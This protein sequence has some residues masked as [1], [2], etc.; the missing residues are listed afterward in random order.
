MQVSWCVMTRNKKGR[1]SRWKCL[2]PPPE[3]TTETP[4]KRKRGK[5]KQKITP[6]VEHV[7]HDGKPVCTWVPTKNLPT[8]ILSALQDGVASAHRLRFVTIN[9]RRLAVPAEAHPATWNKSVKNVN[10][11]SSYFVSASPRRQREHVRLADS[12]FSSSDED[13]SHN[14]PKKKSCRS[15]VG[16]RICQEDGFAHDFAWFVQE[17][18]D[19]KGQELWENAEID[20]FDGE[21]LPKNKSSSPSHV[22]QSKIPDAEETRIDRMMQQLNAAKSR[23]PKCNT[24]EDIVHQYD[25]LMKTSGWNTVTHKKLF[26]ARRFHRFLRTTFPETDNIVVSEDRSTWKCRICAGIGQDLKDGSRYI[27]Q[28]V[29]KHFLSENH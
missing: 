24:W 10:A 23:V 1:G 5:G 28:N 29:S 11:V 15:N 25:S 6:V 2:P 18:G 21:S 12:D 19:E 14:P 17:F 8:E 22:V 26:P 9:S 3:T 20:D 13:Y 27:R 16:L 7:R 4:T